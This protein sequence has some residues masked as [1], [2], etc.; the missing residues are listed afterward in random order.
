[1]F[2][3]NSAL[4]HISRTICMM[5]CINTLRPRQHGHHF[6]DDIF[7]C[8]KILIFW[9]TLHWKLSLMTRSTISKHYL[10][11]CLASEHTTRYYLNQWWLTLLMHTCTN[12]PWCFNSFGPNDAIWRQRSGSTLAQVMAC[13][14]MA[15]SHYLNQCWLIISEVQWHSY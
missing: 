6:A 9:F 3:D 12:Q 8:T 15:P 2:G 14:L 4:Y 5:F 1:M 13:C 11:L 10:R 7:R